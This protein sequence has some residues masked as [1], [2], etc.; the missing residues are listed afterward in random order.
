MALSKQR[1]TFAD[2][3]QSLARLWENCYYI[4]ETLRIRED[5]ATGKNTGG[6]LLNWPDPEHKVASMQAVGLNIHVLNTLA[7][8]WCP[9]QK[10][11]KS[12]NIRVLKQEAIG[13]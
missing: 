7:D 12:P 2:D 1:R 3:P 8:W 10:V 6:K 5:P 9:K 11:P 4:R 13:C